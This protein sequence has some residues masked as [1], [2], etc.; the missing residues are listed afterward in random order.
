MFATLQKEVN[1]SIMLLLIEE[2]LR[3]LVS[4]TKRLEN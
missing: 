4:V 1:I 3:L 2:I